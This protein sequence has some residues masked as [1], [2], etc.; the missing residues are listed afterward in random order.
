MENVFVGSWTLEPAESRFDPNHRPAEA[1]MRWELHPE[2]FYLMKAEGVNA[3]GEK[4]AERPQK[5]VPDGR[6]YAVPDLPGL[7]AVVTQPDPRT[8]CARVTREDGSV[9]GEERYAV[10]PDGTRMTAT[11]SGYDSQIRRFEMQTAW[12]RS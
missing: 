4:C 1:I 12:R 7:T 9:V 3:K 8:V 2:G 5:M 6:P 11:N 10:S